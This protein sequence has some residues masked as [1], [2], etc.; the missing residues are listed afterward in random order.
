MADNPAGWREIIEITGHADTPVVFAMEPAGVADTTVLWDAP[1]ELLHGVPVVTAG[2]RRYDLASWLEVCGVEVA[3]VTEDP[4]R[5]VAE[6]PPGPVV[7]AANRP[8]FLALRSR[9]RG[10]A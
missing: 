6:L 2:A 10:R 9:L 7:L 3:G 4:L 8:A 5:A 1:G